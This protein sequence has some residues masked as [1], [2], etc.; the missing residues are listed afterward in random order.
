MNTENLLNREQIADLLGVARSLAAD[1]LQYADAPPVV[2]RTN[3]A[4]FYSKTAVVQWLQTN[5]YERHKE[6][7]KLRKKTAETQ[8]RAKPSTLDQSL[9]MP[10]LIAPPLDDKLVIEH[11]GTGGTITEHLTERHD[12]V[13]PHSGYSG[14]R[15][16]SNCEYR[17]LNLM[18]I[19]LG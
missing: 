14:R 8:T 16:P 15:A 6:A 5:P 4:F 19:L 13:P 2:L 12:Y 1:L 18:G 3:K 9:A 17:G 10:F 7:I 11:K